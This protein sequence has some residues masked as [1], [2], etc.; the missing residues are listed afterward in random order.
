MQMY[1]AFQI[2]HFFIP[3]PL[4]FIITGYICWLHSGNT[5]YKETYKLQM[6]AT[7]VERLIEFDETFSFLL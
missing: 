3:T 6:E 2:I 4:P 1:N 7:G 5:W